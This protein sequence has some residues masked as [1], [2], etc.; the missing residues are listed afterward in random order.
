MSFHSECPQSS[1]SDAHGT[2]MEKPVT[3]ATGCKDSDANY[4]TL[5][6]ESRVFWPNFLAYSL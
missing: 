6:M 1:T 2:Q 5:V 4:F 3:Y